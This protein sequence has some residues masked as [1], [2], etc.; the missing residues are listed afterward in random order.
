[1]SIAFTSC[2]GFILLAEKLFRSSRRC[3]VLLVYMLFCEGRSIFYKVCYRRIHLSRGKQL[4]TNAGYYG[5]S[6]DH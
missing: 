3:H 6:G 1:M 5:T 4:L 2:V